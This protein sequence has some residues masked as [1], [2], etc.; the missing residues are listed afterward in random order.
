[1]IS[2][3]FYH[4]LKCRLRSP[5]PPPCTSEASNLHITLAPPVWV[6]YWS[7]IGFQTDR[8]LANHPRRGRLF[9][10]GF[11]SDGTMTLST[12]GRWA[13]EKKEGI[14]ICTGSFELRYR[15]RKTYLCQNII[16]LLAGFT[17]MDVV[18]RGLFDKL[19]NPNQFF[20][21]YLQESLH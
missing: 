2:K 17:L 3:V 5:N 10:I 4:F 8:D 1:M 7:G 14:V 21:S 16:F 19:K 20:Q 15:K 12:L 18:F 6:E 13:W 11:F 9:K